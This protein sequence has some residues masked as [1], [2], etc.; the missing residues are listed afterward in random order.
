MLIIRDHVAVSTSSCSLPKS[1]P[2]D[3]LGQNTANM[4]PGYRREAQVPT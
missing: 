1:L 4:S 3:D 2:T